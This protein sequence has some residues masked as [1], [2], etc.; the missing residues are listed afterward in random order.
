MFR[1]Y[2][3]KQSRQENI[4]YLVLWG[5]LFLVP[6]LSLYVRTVSDTGAVFD[7]TEVFVVW[8]K[9]AVYLFLFLLHNF[10]LAPLLVYG[11]KRAVYFSIVAV[12]LVVF[13]IYQCNSRPEGWELKGHKPPRMEHLDKHGPPMDFGG[14]RPPMPDETPPREQ[15]P[16]MP[17]PII[18]EHD[19][20]AVVVLI[21]MFGA[22][23]GIK[24]YFRG[25]DDRKRL[26]ELERQHLEQQ[27]EYLR[28]QINPHFFMN[29]L[30]N[31]HALVDIDPEKAKDTIRELSTMM[32]FVLYEGN[33]EAVQ[34]SREFDFIRH[35]VALMQIRYTDK[36]RINV[37]LPQEVPDHRIPPLLLITFIEN[38][39]KHGVSYQHESFIEVKAAIEGNR[40]DF[41]CRNSKADK[42]NE[43][44]GGVGLANVRK[45]LDL[46]YN[47][48]YTLN[49]LN[50]ADVYTVELNIPLS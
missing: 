41:S 15:H 28:Y 6:V 22:N 45:R 3:L 37:D 10:L 25:R 21:L 39:F 40:L 34:L 1:K 46:L 32:R 42:P 27:L 30:N 49:I 50:E 26:A 8:R 11:R 36:V 31:I 16:D 14:E 17:P 7:W 44:K 13:T 43:E 48:D 4:I 47:R 33:K 23:L 12:M 35:Y 18:G 19:I 9:F 20:L 24:A 29:T 2:W 38:A 5:V